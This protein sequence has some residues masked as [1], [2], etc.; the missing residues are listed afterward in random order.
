MNYKF[1]LNILNIRLAIGGLEI[2]DVD[3]K[4]VQPKKD[5]LF[6]VTLKLEKDVIKEG[7]IN[8]KAKFLENLK[9]LHHQINGG[10]N[11]PIYAVVNIPDNN[12]YA[13]IINLPSVVKANFSEAVK[14]NLQM[15][16]PIDFNNAYYDWQLISEEVNSE[17][18]LEIFAA[19]VHKQIIDDYEEVFKK[20]GFIPVAFEFL[21]LSLSRLVVDLASD[22]DVSKSYILLHI[23]TNG[24]SFNLI[25][26]GNLYFNHF[27]S[28]QSAYAD[29][30]VVA[31]ESFKNL[32]IEEIRRVLSFYANHWGG[33]VD[34]FILVSL[35]LEDEIMKIVSEKF[36]FNIKKLVLKKFNNLDRIFYPVLGSV[37]R[38]QIL[39]SKDT[40]ISL[41]SVGTEK[42]FEKQRVIN[43]VKVWRNIILATLAS[44][45]VIFAVTELFFTKIANSL[46]NQ[47]SGLRGES[48][49]GEITELQS[50]VVEIN[51]KI[52]LALKA[53]NQRSHWS[54]IFE[55]II[56]LGGNDIELT[57][58]FIQSD[59]A[60]IAINALAKD[61]AAALA[62]KTSILGDSDFTDISL[63]LDKI[64]PK[65]SGVEFF[66]SFKI[67]NL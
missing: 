49:I 65:K 63:P 11:K 36:S 25:R 61:E 7:K 57:R 50:E 44:M 53:D 16:S 64:A 45:V 2:N 31:Y 23:G 55:K 19:F 37:L 9:K 66:I 54:Q 4:Y 8:D 24:L 41:S 5:G 12:V 1:L 39:R 22:I 62:F 27:V 42:E 35:G 10:K 38:G 6:S 18:Q 43:F 67:K 47:L 14:L 33:Q 13:Q 28:W 26:N 40:L 52:E 32:V 59:N 15:V 56:N 34:N 60:P 3:L 30:R 58:I 51:K 46:D 29:K 21:A 20:A 17:G 48:E